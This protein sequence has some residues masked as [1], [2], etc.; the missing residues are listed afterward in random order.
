LVHGTKKA[1]RLIDVIDVDSMMGATTLGR[2]Q[3]IGGEVFRPFVLG[4]ASLYEVY[5][6]CGFRTVG[7]VTELATRESKGMDLAGRFFQLVF[8]YVLPFRLRR[9]Q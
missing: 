2:E 3:T 1:R 7:I 9:E 8:F 5:T 6:G 4:F